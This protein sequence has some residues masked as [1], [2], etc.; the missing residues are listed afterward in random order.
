MIT[1]RRFLTHS[2]ALGAATATMAVPGSLAAAPATQDL[3]NI[4]FILA[5]DMGYGDVSSLNAESLIPTP[6]I[7]R[8]THAG[9]YFTDAHSPSALCT[10]T[11]YGV[12]TGRYCFR[13]RV[14][15][16]VLWGYSKHLIELI[17]VKIFNFC[18]MSCTGVWYDNIDP[19]ELATD[20]FKCLFHGRVFSHIKGDYF[21]LAL[22]ISFY[23]DGLNFLQTRFVNI[24]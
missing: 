10:P 21:H 16:G 17:R 15:R 3:P 8:I 14:K 18:Y 5:D 23:Q 2:C 6:N 4:V 13:T 24:G 19:T 20:F 7:D 1:R 22:G 11:R 12:L 9:V